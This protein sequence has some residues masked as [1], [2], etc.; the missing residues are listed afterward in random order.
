MCKTSTKKLNSANDTLHPCP[1]KV[2]G[3]TCQLWKSSKPIQPIFHPNLQEFTPPKALWSLYNMSKPINQ[4]TLTP[5]D[6]YNSI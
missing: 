4:T 3:P 6:L 1:L 5:W 2:Y